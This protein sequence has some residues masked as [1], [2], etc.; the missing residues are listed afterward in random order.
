M[1][2]HN[3]SPQQLKDEFDRIAD[4]REE[5]NRRIATISIFVFIVIGI[6]LKFLFT[7]N[8]QYICPGLIVLLFVLSFPKILREAE[9]FVQFLVGSFVIGILMDVGF[10]IEKLP[11]NISQSILNIIFTIAFAT[12]VFDLMVWGYEKGTDAMDRY[13]SQKDV[14]RGEV[15]D[16]DNYNRLQPNSYK[17]LGSGK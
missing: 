1:K 2:A 8:S 11:I 17:R 7:T 4:E 16:D 5:K 13:E 14:L 10:L 6:S 3:L 12:I 9:M 15:V